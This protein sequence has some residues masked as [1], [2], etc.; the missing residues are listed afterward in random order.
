MQPAPG[1]HL[2]GR[3]HELAAVSGFLDEVAAAGGALL[4]SGQPGLGKTE[5]LKVAIAAAASAGIFVLT[6]NGAEFEAGD[7]YAALDQLVR[8]LGPAFDHLSPVH[9]DALAVVLGSGEGPEYDAA[10]V[11]DA[12]L[13]VIRRVAVAGP[14]LLVVDDLQWVDRSSA[15]VLGVLAREVSAGRIG[16]LAA[17]RPDEGSCFEGSDLPELELRPLDAD[18]AAGL[19]STRFPMLARRS[20][21]R[22]LDEAQGNPLALLELPTALSD[23][24]RR[25]QGPLPDLL[26]LSHPLL[27]VFGSQVTE[28][29]A[30][31]RQLLLLA[32]LEGSGDLRLVMSAGPDESRPGDLEPAERARLVFIDHDTQRV[33]FRHPLVRSTVVALAASS[34]RRTAHGR[35]ARALA[36]QPERQAGHLAEATIEPDEKVATLVEQAAHQILRRGEVGDAVTALLHS[37][38]LSPHPSARARRLAAAAHVGALVGGDLRDVSALL[39]EARR[40]D[41][42]A[43]TSLRSNLA[44]SYALLNGEGAVDAAHRLLVPPAPGCIGSDADADTVIEAMH[45]LLEICIHGGRAELWEPFDSALAR[46]RPTIPSDLALL[47]SVLG[48]PAHAGGG[49]LD[50]LDSAIATLDNE[51]DAT[52]I[53]RLATAA[54]YVDR[55][56]G[57]REALWRVVNDGRK[58]GAVASAI[59]AMAVLSLDLYTA[60]R[61]D[62]SELVCSEGIGL[63][64]LHGYRLTASRLKF[65]AMLLAACRG[66]MDT[67]RALSGEVNGWAAPRGLRAVQFECC[68]ARALAAVARGDFEE[69]YQQASAITP[70]GALAPRVPH[71]LWVAWDLVESAV[72][73]NRR[74]EAE[75]HVRAMSETN[76]AELSPRFALV[77]AGAVGITA[78]DDAAVEPFEQALSI[79]GVARWPFDLARVQLAYGERLRR[80]R[81]TAESR[82]QLT[83]ALESFEQLGARPWVK[84]AVNELQASGLS[85]VRTLGFGSA[86]LTPQQREVASLAASGLSNKQIAD[87]LFVSHRT[88][89]AHLRQI[90]PKLGINSRAAL[91]DALPPVAEDALGDNQTNR[92]SRRD[93]A[94]IRNDTIGGDAR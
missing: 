87:R 79:P 42:G 65:G 54:V 30:I 20:V 83:A 51:T 50:L 25:G 1:E 45:T 76:M 22:V 19:V 64:E 24:Q 18:A 46:L 12:V 93:P 60:G 81:A 21:Q 4:L 72:R 14:I 41:L 39:G 9:R 55:A 67:V 74:R 35:L 53:E 68:H 29:P 77:L 91:R 26:P 13:A 70:L 59:N 62:E 17:L 43:A 27:S 71:A 10:I 33:E 75:A 73:T 69:A 40:V 48:D 84:R 47:V 89:G 63:A 28:L 80:M 5:L 15:A 57:C 78:R 86:S 2:F 56:D 7:S 38:V 85:K 3:A 90:F 34:E 88:V 92:L 6:A 31:T 82:Q 66:Q 58:G 49:D 8:P 94:T 16:F 36:D 52:R 37:A 32:A 11:S 23:T 44:A 61:W